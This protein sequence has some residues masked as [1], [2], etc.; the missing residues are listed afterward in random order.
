[1]FI[2]QFFPTLYNNLSIILLE[3]ISGPIA[4]GLF[5]AGNKFISIMDQ[6]SQALSRAFYPFLARRMD[7]HSVYVKI[8]CSI[9][10]VMSLFLLL[11]ANLI[12]NIFFTQEFHPAIIVTRIMACSPFFLFLMNSYGTNGLVLIGKDHILRNIVVLCSL[13][14]MGLSILGIFMWSYIGVAIAI[15]ATW[16]IRGILSY[17]YFKKYTKITNQQ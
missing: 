8:S 9:S 11:G 4:N 17:I 6:V 3:G 15:T 13:F 7:K 1:M 16:A 5:S 10:I 14:G 12:I 2:A